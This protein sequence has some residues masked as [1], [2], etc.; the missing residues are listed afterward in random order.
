MPVLA[1]VCVPPLTLSPVPPQLRLTATPSCL[2][3]FSGDTCPQGTRVTL[4]DPFALGARSLV[5]AWG[6]RRGCVKP[7]TA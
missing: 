4:Q 3:A 7:C 6:R 2:M 5:Q 1:Q